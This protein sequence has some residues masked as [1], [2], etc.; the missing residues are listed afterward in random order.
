MN[1][2]QG[3]VKE[4][5]RN[6]ELICLGGKPERSMAEWDALE[7]VVEKAEDALGNNDIAEMRKCYFF[8]KRQK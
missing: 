4:I 5:H 8:L 7:S 2:V 1:L 3:L 6:V